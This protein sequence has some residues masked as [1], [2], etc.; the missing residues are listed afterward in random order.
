MY[1]YIYIGSTRRGPLKRPE[2]ITLRILRLRSS[3]PSFG[4][5]KVRMSDFRVE[6]PQ[7]DLCFQG[8]LLQDCQSSSL[9]E[10]G[11]VLREIE[12]YK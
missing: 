1:I 9:P 12:T 5:K 6:I 2:T 3:C 4:Q 8:K 7:V 11:N 10:E